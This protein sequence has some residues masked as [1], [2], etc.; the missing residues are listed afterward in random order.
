MTLIEEQADKRARDIWGVPLEKVN[1]TIREWCYRQAQRDLEDKN[2]KT[3][4]R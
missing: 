3:I 1:E 2:V 4:E